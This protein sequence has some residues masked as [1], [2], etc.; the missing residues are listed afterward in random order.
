MTNE[1]G[2]DSYL[3]HLRKAANWDLI[4]KGHQEKG[5]HRRAEQCRDEAQKHR[6]KALD[7]FERRVA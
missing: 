1:T 5:F 2:R 6:D 7:A 4:A 3:W